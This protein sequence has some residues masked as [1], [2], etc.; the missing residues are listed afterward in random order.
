MMPF[1]HLHVYMPGVTF[2]PRLI[3]RLAI[4]GLSV[5][6]MT[7][8]AQPIRVSGVNYLGD[9]PTVVAQHQ[10]LFEFHGLDVAIEYS[11]SGK[12]NLEKLRRGETDI[13][14]MALTPVLLDRLADSTPGSTDDPVILA[15][16][17]HST[18]L[19]QVIAI[20]D[21]TID[22]AID[23]QNRKV[24][25][26]KGTNAEFMWWLFA[27][28]NG[29]DPMSVDLIDQPIESIPDALINEEVSAAVIWE[30]WITRL[31]QRVPERV[32]TFGGSDIYTAKWVIVTTRHYLG[33]HASVVESFLSAYRDSFS[34]I[35]N[36]PDQ[37]IRIFSEH[38]G[39]AE[40]ILRNHWQELDYGLNLDWSL[41]IA[42]QQQLEWAR[43]SGYSLTGEEID[44]L[45][46]MEAAPMREVAPGA[47]GIPRIPPA[48][49]SVP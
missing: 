27:H 30:P 13:A 6:C 39:V 37:A 40:E 28:Y 2:V 31:Q 9:L 29:F 11:D 41:V 23:L 17:V 4:F 45:S 49:R 15:N 44:I 20:A 24:G 12:I 21:G 14:L 26:V 25:L 1:C 47:V 10:N 32:Q 35:D 5:S 38:T 43:H 19:N 34:F 36:D 22:S 18:R 8:L 46:L 3:C 16:L 48:E 42:L 7:A 33:Q